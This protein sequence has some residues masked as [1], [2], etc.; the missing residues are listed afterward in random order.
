MG[1][2]GSISRLISS[3]SI[4]IM[5][6][7]QEHGSKDYKENENGL[8]FFRK[9]GLFDRPIGIFECFCD[10]LQASTLEGKAPSI[11]SRES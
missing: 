9:G 1:M 4:F 2:T 5:G 8:M 11:E 10:E 6:Y 7:E 3:V